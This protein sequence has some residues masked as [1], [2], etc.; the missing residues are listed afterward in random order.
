MKQL[1]QTLVWVRVPTSPTSSLPNGL[2][3]TLLV[4][5]T[6]RPPQLHSDSVSWL[7]SALLSAFRGTIQRQMEGVIAHAIAQVTT[8]RVSIQP[9]ALSALPAAVVATLLEDRGMTVPASHLT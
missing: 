4:P 2:T 3:P 7:Y 6:P 1:G 8:P 9:L 5:P